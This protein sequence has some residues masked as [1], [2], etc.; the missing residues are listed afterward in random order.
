MIVTVT[1]EGMSHTFYNINNGIISEY[2]NNE[3]RSLK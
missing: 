1:K 3:I 2:G